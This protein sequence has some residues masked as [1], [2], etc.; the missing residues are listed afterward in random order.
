[1]ARRTGKTA[2]IEI[3]CSADDQRDWRRAAEE[4]G[5]T[6]A[7]YVRACLGRG[8]RLA[9]ISRADPALVRQI[10]AI[11]NNLNQLA[12]WAHIH[13]SAEEAWRVAEKICGARQALEALLTQEVGRC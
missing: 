2:R 10:A 1:M 5:L 6:L 7:A 9:R 12:R 4:H 8:P 11:G 3:R 13:K